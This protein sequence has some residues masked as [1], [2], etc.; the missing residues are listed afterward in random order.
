MDDWEGRRGPVISAFAARCARCGGDFVHVE[1]EV[2]EQ[3][4]LSLLV[5]LLHYAIAANAYRTVRDQAD[6]KDKKEDDEIELPVNI[7]RW[8]TVMYHAKFWLAVA[9]YAVITYTF[10]KSVGWNALKIL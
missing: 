10:V 1:H 7:N 6:D 3:L 5:D 8:P 2:V 4:A 9:G